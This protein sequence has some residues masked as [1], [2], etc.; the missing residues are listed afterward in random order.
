[1]AEEI[2]QT[3]PMLK[4]EI[5]TSETDKDIQENKIIALLS[6]IGI[7]FL[8]P[9]LVKKDSKFAKFHAKQGLVL[10]IGW[11]SVWIPVLGGFCGLVMM[12][13]SI[14]GI[15]NVLSGKYADLPIIGDL[16]KKFNI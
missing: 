4:P 12:I 16:A 10:F 1:M 6:Y 15:I 9:L 3:T 11:F 5:P 14:L 7:L 2:P 8:V 13:L